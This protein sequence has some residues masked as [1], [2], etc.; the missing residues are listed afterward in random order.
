MRY[1][2]WAEA[3]VEPEK[4]KA[5]GE[6]VSLCGV[7]SD[8][9]TNKEERCLHGNMDTGVFN[10]KN[11]GRTGSVGPVRSRRES[12]VPYTEPEPVRDRPLDMDM[13]EWL[14]V[15]RHIKPEVISRLE[16]FGDA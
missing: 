16:L 15:E 5:N 1:A 6:F 10:C 3:G 12:P 8:Q 13:F 9:R 4:L 7:C 11:C 2:T 14:V